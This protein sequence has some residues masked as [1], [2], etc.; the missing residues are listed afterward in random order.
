[1][2]IYLFISFRPFQDFIIIWRQPTLNC[3]NYRLILAIGANDIWTFVDSLEETYISTQGISVFPMAQVL[4]V[5]LLVVI[6]IPVVPREI[7][8]G[9]FLQT[10]FIF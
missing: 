10:K 3:C 9:G 2:Y 4:A 5:S 1:M 8:G 7:G 6:V